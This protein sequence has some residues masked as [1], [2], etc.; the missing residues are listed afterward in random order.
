MDMKVGRSPSFEREIPTM[1][2]IVNEGS[3]G[4]DYVTNA[5]NVH[6]ARVTFRR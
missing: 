3:A 1:F 4:G 5:L 6:A 2:N